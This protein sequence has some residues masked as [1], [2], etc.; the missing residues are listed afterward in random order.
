VKAIELAL[1]EAGLGQG[2]I[3]YVNAHGTSTP[4]NDRVES[5]VIQS[6]FGSYSQEIAVTSTK[7]A[8]GHLLG[9]AGA[10]EA[11]ASLKAME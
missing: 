5:H 7:A 2:D 3:Q 9:A 11:I 1:E 4:T 6:A 8:V 10:V